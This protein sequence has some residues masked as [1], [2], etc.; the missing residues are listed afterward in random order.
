[1]LLCGAGEVE[2]VLGV[3]E[4]AE[5]AGAADLAPVGVTELAQ[6]GGHGFEG[7]VEGVGV[8]RVEKTGEVGG[9][10]Q[11]VL[12][13]HPTLLSGGSV[14]FGGQVGLQAHDRGV[15]GPLDACDRQLGCERCEGGVD[16]ISGFCLQH[17][18]ALSDAAGLPCRQRA[19][20]D[21]GEAAGETIA[22]LEGLGDVGASGVLA[23]AEGGGELG[24]G[25]L[26]DHE[27]ALAC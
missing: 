20:H 22:Q 27:R 3:G 7:V 12:E 24:H 2:G 16:G 10:V 4:H 17:E 19:A 11:P 26:G 15:D 1:M 13:P 21:L 14:A 9:A 18:G 8:G 5:G 25:V 23:E 6:G